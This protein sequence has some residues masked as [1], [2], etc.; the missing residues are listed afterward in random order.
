MFQ[1]VILMLVNPYWHLYW[2]DEVMLFT[3]FQPPLLQAT[4][5]P[6]SKRDELIG[7]CLGCPWRGMQQNQEILKTNAHKSQFG[8]GKPH[9]KKQPWVYSSLV[10][11]LK[12]Q[13][14]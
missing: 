2:V 3:W 14:Y 10:D 7:Q 5:A 1:L 4:F 8:P 11:E 12:K 13:I 9:D 6:S